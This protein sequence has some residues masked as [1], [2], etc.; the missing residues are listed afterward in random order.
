MLAFV[1]PLLVLSSDESSGQDGGLAGKRA[2]ETTESK[3]AGAKYSPPSLLGFNAVSFSSAVEPPSDLRFK[4]LNENS[5][6]MSWRRPSARIQ[7][8]RIQVVSDS[9]EAVRDFTLDA[10]TSVTSITD[11]TPDL[12][13]SVSIN[14]F[15]GS[16]ES[17]PIFGQLTI[18]SGNSSDRVRRP[19]DT[20][21][22]YVY[23]GDSQELNGPYSVSVG[24]EVVVL[25]MGG[26]ECPTVNIT[27][28]TTQTS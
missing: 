19:T 1:L 24:V 2:R 12:D 10:Y 16:E 17:I 14:S 25:L 21:S 28:N 11:L 26:R 20:V 22:K 6:E 3:H 4:I 18:Q 5:V 13:Y 15:D 27:P 8:F 7:G 23:P 9:D